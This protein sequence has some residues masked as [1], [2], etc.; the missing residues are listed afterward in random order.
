MFLAT[1]KAV[2]ANTSMYEHQWLCTSRSVH[3]CQAPT[4]DAFL[5]CRSW[6]PSQQKRNRKRASVKQKVNG[7][8][9]KSSDESQT[10][11]ILP[12]AAPNTQTYWI[13]FER[14]RRGKKVKRASIEGK[15]VDTGELQMVCVP[16]QTVC[17]LPTQAKECRAIWWCRRKTVFWA[18]SSCSAL[19]STQ[20]RVDTEV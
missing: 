8:Y 20:K 19:I 14:R 18:G 3:H 15:L 11:Q 17:L 6:Q 12:P 4:A 1:F 16:K 2:Q 7:K 13:E 10:W 9:L 5:R